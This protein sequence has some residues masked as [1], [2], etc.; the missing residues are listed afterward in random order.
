MHRERFRVATVPA[1]FA[2]HG[3]SV[4]DGTFQGQHDPQI[5]PMQE[6]I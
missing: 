2:E 6:A 1:H 4:S 5:Y 3:S